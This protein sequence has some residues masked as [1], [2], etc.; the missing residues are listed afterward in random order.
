MLLTL[1][2]FCCHNI[3]ENQGP[4]ANVN[5]LIFRFQNSRTLSLNFP[6]A[7]KIWSSSNPVW[8]VTPTL[9]LYLQYYDTC[10]W[11]RC[12]VHGCFA[13][14]TRRPMTATSNEPTFIFDVQ[15]L[16]NFLGC[17]DLMNVV[18]CQV[19]KLKGPTEDD[20]N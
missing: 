14:T 3:W 13:V 6:L 19:A 1:N 11:C 5:F 20:D 8:K 2:W 4:F 12:K 15:S 17:W 18:K 7:D 10:I 9:Y 16:I